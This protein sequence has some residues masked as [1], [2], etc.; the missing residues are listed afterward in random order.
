VQHHDNVTT[1][2]ALKTTEFVTNNNI[3]ILPHPSYLLDLD[4]S[5]LALFP[6]LKVKLKGRYFVTVSDIQSAFEA[7][8]K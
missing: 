7:W 6:K 8:R 2:L 5:D 1:H 3:V 4:S